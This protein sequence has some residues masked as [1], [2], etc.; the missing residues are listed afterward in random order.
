MTFGFV[1]FFLTYENMFRIA[2]NTTVS[3]RCPHIGREL[4]K[5]VPGLCLPH[6]RKQWPTVNLQE[7]SEMLG[8]F[9]DYYLWFTFFSYWLVTSLKHFLLLS[10]LKITLNLLSLKLCKWI[11]KIMFSVLNFLNLRTILLLHFK[12]F[13][14]LNDQYF[15]LS[16]LG[17]IIKLPFTVFFHFPL[18]CLRTGD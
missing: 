17:A 14:K 3:E 1:C 13:A 8:M 9:C 11:K 18:N 5:L 12:T 6:S 7:R 10:D 4:H 2:R 16:Q 15:L